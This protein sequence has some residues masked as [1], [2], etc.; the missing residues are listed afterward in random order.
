MEESIMFKLWEER[1]RVMR[2]GSYK[3]LYWIMD[4]ETYHKLAQVEEFRFENLKGPFG[5]SLFDIPIV[6]TSDVR[7][8][9]LVVRV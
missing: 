2:T 7:G 3:K 4:H 1:R 5:I 8:F 6:R 9:E